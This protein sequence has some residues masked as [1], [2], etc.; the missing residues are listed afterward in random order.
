MQTTEQF[1]AASKRAGMTR[2]VL[3]TPSAGG[4]EQSADALFRD[5]SE[6]VLGS[7][8]FAYDVSISYPV[9]KLVGLKR[10][11]SITVDGVA[12]K[13]REDP[14]SDIGNGTRMKATLAR[15]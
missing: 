4:A 10:G 14:R 5:V 7:A 1:F 3:W 12:F 11:E 2:T 8:A 13:V 15:V 6:E 9:T